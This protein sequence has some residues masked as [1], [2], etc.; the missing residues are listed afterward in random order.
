MFL[1][2]KNL[3]FSIVL[4]ISICTLIVYL[5]SVYQAVNYLLRIDLSKISEEK[6]IARSQFPIVS[7]I[8]PALNEEE[9]IENCV[10]SV[11]IN[12]R[13]TPDLLEVWVVNDQ[14]I[15]HTSEILQTLQTQWSE[16]RLKILPGLPHPEDQLWNGKSWACQQGSEQ[17]KGE[18]LLFIDADIRLKPQAILAV[19]QTAIDQQLDFL[20]CI[21]A[22]ASGSL[23]EW[24]VQPLMFIN[25]LATFNFKAGNSSRTKTNYALGRFLLFRA[26]AY[27]AIGGHRAIAAEVTEDV[28]FARKIK[29]SG[30]RMQ[31]VMGRNITA[32]RTYR[33]WRALWEDWIKVLSVDAE[34]SVILMLL[35]AI[36]MLLIYTVPWIGLIISTAQIFRH[37]TPF[38]IVAAGL[39]SLAIFLQYWVRR[40]GSQALGTSTKYWW[41]QGA[42]GAIIAVLAIASLIK[43]ETG[44]GWT[45]RGR[46][47]TFIKKV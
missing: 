32:L 44:W 1:S 18:F 10:K 26:D 37:P 2:N 17:A 6:D 33:N 23:I 46:Q 47:L 27:N 24:L 21:P 35:L 13:L 14:S 20:T 39:A 41:L 8:I 40:W 16:P 19:V 7:V 38:R 43:T 25:A 4:L 34:R 30:F 11:L 36:V 12:T 45:W 3:I 9:N 15:D 29:R 22:I 5:V 28:A 31:H 42:G